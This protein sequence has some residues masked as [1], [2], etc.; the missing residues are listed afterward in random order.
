MSSLLSELQEIH[1]PPLPGLWPPAPGW[2]MLAMLLMGLVAGWLIWRRIRFAPRWI[3]LRE[4]AGLDAGMRQGDDHAYVAA[5]SCLLRRVALLHYPRER[6]A[7]LHGA[8]WRDFL[9]A[10][11]GD[12]AFAGPAGAALEAAYRREVALEA[13]ALSAAVRR[14]IGA[15]PW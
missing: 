10:H 3:A 7:A 8:Q 11:G 15:Q 14:W 2:W 4:L 6:V 5:V 12:G 1:L 13:T 9:D